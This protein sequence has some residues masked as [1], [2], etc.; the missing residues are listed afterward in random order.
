MNSISPRRLVPSRSFRGL[1][2]ARPDKYY[3]LLLA[4]LTSGKLRLAIADLEDDADAVPHIG[5][6][7]SN[8][9]KGQNRWF[10]CPPMVLVRS[11]ANNHAPY[12]SIT[13]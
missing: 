1:L 10:E 9:V 11:E 8:V 5:D 13:S 6:F 3:K 12:L 4:D 7:W 2:C